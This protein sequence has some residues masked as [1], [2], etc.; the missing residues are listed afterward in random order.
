MIVNCLADG[1]QVDMN[2]GNPG[3]NGLMYVKGYS[4]NEECRKS[5]ARNEDV[6]TV[7]FKIRFNTCGLIHENVIVI[8]LYFVELP[9]VMNMILLV[10]GRIDIRCLT[11]VLQF[12]YEKK[13]RV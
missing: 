9:I 1:V 4:K 2:I 7:D 11:Y 12:I 6:G 5:L 8:Y 3:F 13:K 10:D